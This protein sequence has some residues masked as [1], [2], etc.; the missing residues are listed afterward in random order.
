MTAIR[1][2][3]RAKPAAC[4][5]VLLTVGLLTAGS[6]QAAVDVRSFGDTRVV[7]GQRLVLLDLSVGDV[8]VEA[9]SGDRIE[10]DVVVR[11]SRLSRR[12]RERAESI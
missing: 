3:L 7:E 5:A 8:E 1:S 4:T 10:V 11:C 12:C 2:L 6:A 9:G